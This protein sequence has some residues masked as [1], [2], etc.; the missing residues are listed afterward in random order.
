MACKFFK[1]NKCLDGDE[2]LFEHSNVNVHMNEV[3]T[4]NKGFKKPELCTVGAKCENQSC[5]LN[6]YDKMNILCRFQAK[7]D[8][9]SC[10]YKHH[11]ERSSFLGSG[12]KSRKTK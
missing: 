2:C 12:S 9:H 3:H 8:R 6:H 1:E 4:N 5:D 7:C 10:Q 11:L